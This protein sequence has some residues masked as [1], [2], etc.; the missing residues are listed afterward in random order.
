MET[1][2]RQFKD[3]SLVPGVFASAGQHIPDHMHV[4]HTRYSAR[5]QLTL[6]CSHAPEM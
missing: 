6:L 1:P 5:I 2:E 4:C 3:R